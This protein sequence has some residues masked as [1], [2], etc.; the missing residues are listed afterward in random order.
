MYFWLTLMTRPRADPSLPLHLLS[1]ILRPRL[2]LT[3]SMTSTNNTELVSESDENSL[4]RIIVFI[5]HHQRCV[6]IPRDILHT[7]DTMEDKRDVPC[8]LPKSIIKVRTVKSLLW[9]KDNLKLNWKRII[10]LMC[11]QDDLVW[12]TFHIFQNK[13]R[14]FV[15]LLIKNVDR[16]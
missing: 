2:L 11:W 10:L 7:I 8:H 12:F 4:I 16:V 9:R 1:R 6:N 14:T 3:D 15:Y 13:W 5:F